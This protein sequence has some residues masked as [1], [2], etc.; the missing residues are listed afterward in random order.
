MLHLVGQL[1]DLFGMKLLE[2]TKVLLFAKEDISLV[3]D[4]ALES[5]EIN[6]A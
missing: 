1:G 4:D 2:L 3:K 5:R 6:F